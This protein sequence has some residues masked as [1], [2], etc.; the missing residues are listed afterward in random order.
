MRHCGGGLQN[1]LRVEK[2]D[3]ITRLLDRIVHD[4]SC[5]DRFVLGLSVNVSAMFRD[6]G[7]FRAMRTHV[8][9]LLRA[10]P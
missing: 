10:W 3:T 6:P 9:P 1:R 5:M 2:I 7:F 8:F 4:A